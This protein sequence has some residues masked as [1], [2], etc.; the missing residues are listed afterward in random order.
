MQYHISRYRRQV[1][2]Y[3]RQ[4][5][6]DAFVIFWEILVINQKIISNVIS[7]EMAPR[8][9]QESYHLNVD[10]RAFPINR[11]MVIVLI[12]FAVIHFQLGLIILQLEW[13]YGRG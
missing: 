3:C 8:F 6:S 13:C 4:I 11:L 10:P 2:E 12:T 9:Q 5:R 7:P 1:I